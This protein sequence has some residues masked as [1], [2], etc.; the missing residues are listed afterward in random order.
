MD[1][2]ISSIKPKY[3][4][5]S[6]LSGSDIYLQDNLSFK[7]GKRY[8]IKANSGHGKSS[9]LNFIYGSNLHYTGD[10][11]FDGK[12]AKQNII[13]IRINRLSYVF[14]DFKLFA[15]LSLLDNIKIKNNLTNYKQEQEIIDLID[16]VGLLE[17]KDSLV[18]ELSLG[19]RQ[20][21]AIIRSLCQPFKFLLLDEPFS[22]LDVTNIKIISEIIDEELNNQE[23]GFLLTTL[24]E[25]YFF[26]YDKILNL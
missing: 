7:S 2:S 3:M 4:S 25:E 6:E 9:I 11:T 13:P 26:R 15:E 1:I 19:Q 17:K 8:L 14:Q 10:I 5:E 16:R 18:K 22:H 12:N 20:R 24:N 23:A 21:V